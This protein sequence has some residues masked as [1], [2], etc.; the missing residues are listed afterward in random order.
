MPFLLTH[1]PVEGYLAVFLLL[2]VVK[3]AVMDIGIQVSKSLFPVLGSMYLKV[4]FLDYMVFQFL[5]KLPDS[6]PMSTHLPLRK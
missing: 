3:N 2:A 5:F 4:E 6:F 1:P